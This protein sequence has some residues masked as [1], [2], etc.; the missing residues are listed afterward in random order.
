MARPRTILLTILR[1]IDEKP[2]SYSQICRITKKPQKVIWQNLAIALKEKMIEQDPFKKYHLTIFGRSTIDLAERRLDC[3]SF[4]ASSQIVDLIN[5]RSERPTVKC[6]IQ[7][8]NARK[9]KEL[10]DKSV[11]FERFLTHDGLWL[12]DNNT[13]LKE[14]LAE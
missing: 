13:Y 4:E 12:E 2:V 6:T 10:D 3:I 7:I 8:K 11:A 5:V 14:Q 1:I 9:I